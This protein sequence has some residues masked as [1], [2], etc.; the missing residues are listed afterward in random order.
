MP[1][2]RAPYAATK[3]YS[4]T[5][6]DEKKRHKNGADAR[7]T[8]RTNGGN[9]AGGSGAIGGNKARGKVTQ[10]LHK[11]DAGAMAK[12]RPTRGKS[13]G[14]SGA[15]GRNEAR[16]K[17][18]QKLHKSGAGARYRALCLRMHPD[19]HREDEQSILA[20]TAAAFQRAQAAWEV[21]H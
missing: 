11:S 14:G 2:A 18:T 6:V 19:K 8:S 3:L 7:A 10:K 9:S 13:A 21:L 5:K 20:A 15:I 4:S 17:A 16:A 12:S 1:V